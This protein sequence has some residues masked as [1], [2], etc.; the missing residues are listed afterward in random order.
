[1][2]PEERTLFERIRQDP[3]AAREAVAEYVGWYQDPDTIWEGRPRRLM[4]PSWPGPTCA[5]P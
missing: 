5:M 3:V 1:M 2:T 4:G